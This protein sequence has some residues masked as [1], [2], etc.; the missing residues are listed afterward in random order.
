MQR[1][2]IERLQR[3]RSA[4]DQL[5][6]LPD[7]LLFTQQLTQA[8]AQTIESDKMLGVAFLDLDRFKNI[9]DTLGHEVGDGL[10]KQV[11]SQAVLQAVSHLL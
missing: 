9:N 5:T 7:R 1:A 10:L 6:Q 4:H 8:I 2:Q 11:A 3:S